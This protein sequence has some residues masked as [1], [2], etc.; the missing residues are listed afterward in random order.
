M[1]EFSS[2]FYPNGLD[3]TLTFQFWGAMA[4]ILTA[5]AT[6]LLGL[7]AFRTFQLWKQKAR[8]QHDRELAI[9]YMKD[10]T[11]KSYA[12]TQVLVYVSHKA[13][14]AKGMKALNFSGTI[15]KL[16]PAQTFYFGAHGVLSCLEEKDPL[17]SDCLQKSFVS[18][19]IFGPEIGA[20]YLDL[21]NAH[22]DLHNDALDTADAAKNSEN[23]ATNFNRSDSAGVF[24]DKQARDDFFDK[25]TSNTLKAVASLRPYITDLPEKIDQRELSLLF[26]RSTEAKAPETGNHQT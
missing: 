12:L 2:R 23:N 9:D 13:G 10:I 21:Q 20:V 18:A 7:V 1:T 8:Y 5:G 14:I 15:D 4:N 26:S 3:W 11:D 24:Q 16:S 25:I 17:F 6:L 22:I 19:S